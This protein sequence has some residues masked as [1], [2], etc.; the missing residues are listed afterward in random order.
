M[1]A[2]RL[3]DAA[4]EAEATAAFGVIAAQVRRN[5]RMSLRTLARLLDS[6]KEIAARPV[7]M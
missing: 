7:L 2:G 3:W 5:P 1:G 6:L 4:D